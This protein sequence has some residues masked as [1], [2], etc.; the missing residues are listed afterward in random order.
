MFTLDITGDVARIEL[1]ARKLAVSINLFH[2]IICLNKVRKACIIIAGVIFH[3]PRDKLSGPMKI[4]LAWLDPS[5]T[6]I[7]GETVGCNISSSYSSASWDT[8]IRKFS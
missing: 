6:S 1:F 4:P 2:E 5:R 3:R 7:P 8:Y